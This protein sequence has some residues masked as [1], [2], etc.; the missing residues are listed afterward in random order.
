MVLCVVKKKAGAMSHFTR[1]TNPPTCGSVALAEN[2]P[3]SGRAP[4]VDEAR[5]ISG[6]WSQ[7]YILSISGSLN[8]VPEQTNNKLPEKA[9]SEPGY[10]PAF[11]PVSSVSVG[12][13]L[14]FSQTVKHSN[15]YESGVSRVCHSKAAIQAT[16]SVNVFGSA[17]R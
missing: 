11:S 16:P 15:R 7:T 17:D 9:T 5:W 12:K 13:L 14:G 1:P 6:K 8:A 2:F 4:L 10:S 3:H